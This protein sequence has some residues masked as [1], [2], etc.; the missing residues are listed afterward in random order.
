MQTKKTFSSLKIF[1]SLCAA[2]LLCLAGTAHALS[3]SPGAVEAN[4][5]N[6]TL[7]L[8]LEKLLTSSGLGMS[9][10]FLYSEEHDAGAITLSQLSLQG[11]ETDRRTYRAAVGA[12]IYHYTTPGSTSG[13]AVAFGGLFYHVIPG[14]QRLS[15]GG[16]GWIAPKVTSFGRTEQFYETGA[17]VA[18]RVIQNTDV[19]GGYRYSY[20]KRDDGFDRQFEKG[21]HLGFRI[22]F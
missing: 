3:L 13:A 16:Y 12:R 4:L 2:S 14:A 8:E 7:Q 22:N 19:F 1:P 10:G 11:V 20:L 17:R 9:A 21:P 5:S 15:A 6:D 18:Y